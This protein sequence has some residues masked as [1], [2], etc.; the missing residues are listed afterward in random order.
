MN[1]FGTRGQQQ[2]VIGGDCMFAIQTGS[3]FGRLLHHLKPRK[4]ALN[5]LKVANL[6][7]Q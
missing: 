4:A 7:K 1:M 3:Y 2:S 5:V 6:A